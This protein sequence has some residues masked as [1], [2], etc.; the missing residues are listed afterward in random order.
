MKI[1]LKFNFELYFK[2]QRYLFSTGSCSHA[3]ES[4]LEVWSEERNSQNK[5]C[6]KFNDKKKVNE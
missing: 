6:K 3:D 4:K 1:N 5:T 2:N